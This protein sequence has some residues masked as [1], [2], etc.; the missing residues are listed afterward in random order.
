M[1]ARPTGTAPPA[2][3]GGRMARL[4]GL[5]VAALAVVS[6]CSVFETYA[7]EVN[8]E[9]ITQAELNRELEAILGNE[10]YLEQVDQGFASRGG[11]RALGEGRDTFNTV[12]VA[13]VLD[14]RI[15]FE[16]IHQ[17][18]VRRG[19][20]VTAEQRRQTERELEESYGRDVFRAFPAAYRR[21]LVRIFS[22]VSALGEALGEAAVDDEAVRSFYEENPDAFSQTCVR[23]IL[24]DSEAKAAE[25]KA[26]IAAGESFA[27]L[28]RAESTDN[29]VPNGS[30]QQGGDLGCVAKGS[31]VP[32][33]EAAMEALQ[34]GQVSDPVR[35]QFGYHLI[36]VL[37]RKVVALEEAAP[38][39][40]ENLQSSRPDPVQRFVTEALADATIEVNPRYGSFVKEGPNPGVRAPK[41]LDEPTTTAPPLPEPTPGP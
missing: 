21:D 39:I 36:E 19:I 1:S 3:P 12:F 2:R 32:E 28:A 38:R 10:E 33:F 7:A 34:P 15:G 20:T 6:G 22:E 11:E 5:A 13:A 14:R 23:H 18:A 26:R 41:L 16:L 40:R 30:A 8:G 4:A 29:Q 24:V 17:E 31:L 25:L 9:R 37:E 27:D 35:T